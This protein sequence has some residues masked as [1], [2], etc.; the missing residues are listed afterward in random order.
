MVIDHIAK[1]PIAEGRMDGW[2]R[3]IESGAE[4]P[5]VWCKL[6]GL[7]TEANWKSWRSADLKPY[8][9]HVVQ[10]FGYDRLIYGS[11]WPVCTLAGSYGQTLGAIRDALAPLSND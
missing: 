11:D 5:N 2:D 9:Q 1:P 6:S 10:L 3:D 7:I 4:L 8:V